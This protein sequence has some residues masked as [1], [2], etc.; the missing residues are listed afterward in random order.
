MEYKKTVC[1]VDD[2]VL[3]TQAIAELINTFKD[4]KVIGTYN[5]G[6]SYIKDLEKN[7]FLPDI[8]LMDINMPILN[9]I[10]TTS[11]LT[12]KYPEI[13]VIALSVE[14]DETSVL[15]M[16]RAGAKGYLL[17]DIAKEELKHALDEISLNGFYHDKNVSEILVNSL[18]KSPNKIAIKEKEM[19]FLKLACSEMTYKEIADKMKLSPK[20]ID[21]YR[22]SLFEKLKV[23]NRVGLVLYAIKHKI[24]IIDE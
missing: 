12:K 1:I 16:L 3:L 18:N 19:D 4:F 10:E 13:I 22:N 20:T 7:K 2:H 9:G 5:N 6:S 14:A 21:G 8:T 23:K 24:Y 17:K 15:K 11:F